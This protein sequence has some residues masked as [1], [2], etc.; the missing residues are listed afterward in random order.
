MTKGKLLDIYVM[1]KLITLY[2]LLL[3]L[4]PIRAQVAE[5]YYSDT[6][7]KE[8]G[9]IYD[10]LKYNNTIIV[11]GR[12]FDK[13]K[14]KPAII[15]IDT[16]GTVLWNTAVND[17]TN[18]SSNIVAGKIMRGNDGYIYAACSDGNSRMEMWKVDP[19]SGS[20]IWKKV[21]NFIYYASLPR[22]M[23][24]FDSTR[25]II[26]YPV[27]YNSVTYH[28]R[29]AFVSKATGD[30]LS[31]YFIGNMPGNMPLYG[32]CLDNQ[33]N[34]YFSK[35]DSIYKVSGSNPNNFIWKKRYASVLILDY[36]QIY[37]DSATSSVFFLGR[38][39]ASWE[40]G[41]IMKIDASIGSLIS[42]YEASTGDVAY[43]DMKVVNDYMYVTW[44]HIYVGGG[45]YPYYLTKY[46]MS[47]ATADWSIDYSFSGGSSSAMSIDLDN[48]GDIYL[49]GYYGSANYG[50]AN[51]GV[52]KIKGTDGSPVYAKT[53]TED[54]TIGNNLSIGMAA[55]V[56]NNTPYFVGELE[57]TH[58]PSMRESLT[59]V[60]LDPS[61]GSTVLRKYIGGYY[62]FP[63][64]TLAIEKYP[65]SQTIVMK[66]TG[67]V[68]ELELYDPAKNLL[69]KKTFVKEYYL[70]GGS[71]AIAPNGDIYM[72]AC[73]KK[74]S[75]SS[76]FYSN[77]TDSVFILQLNSSGGI[78]K[79]Y[80][81]YDGTS[82]ASPVEMYVDYSG[83]LLFYQKNNIIYY[84][85]IGNSLLS[86][87]Y[88]S[89]M[90]YTNVVS[91]TKYC[92]NKNLYKA[93]LFGDFSGT[94]RLAEMDRFTMAITNLA[95]FP[96]QLKKINYALE[97]DTNLV[98]ICAK[99]SLN[100][101]SLGLYNTYIKD[102]VWAKQLSNNSNSQV[103]KCVTD[104]QKNYAY[105]ISQSLANIVV[106]K[107]AISNGQL[108]WAFTYNGAANL[109]DYPV[110]IIYDPYRN[111][112]LVTGYETNSGNKRALIL[113]I[114]S[115]G[116]PLDT[117]IKTGD[118]AGDNYGLCAQVLTDRSQWVGGNLNKNPF[119]SA[120]YIFELADST[121]IP[122][123]R[124]DNSAISV[125]ESVGIVTVKLKIANVN[126]KASSVNIMNTG[127][128][129]VNS[130]YFA[131]IT[132][133]T[134]PASAIDG[135]SIIVTYT[136][137]DDT[138]LESN[139][140]IVAG[141][142]AANNSVVS[143]ASKTITII[144]DD[145]PAIITIDTSALQVFEH[146]GT[147]NV[148]MK[149]ANV[150]G[151]AS[152]VNI[153]NTGTATA[154]SD[155]TAPGPVVTF[156]ASAVNGDS[157]MVTYTIIDD[158]IT[159]STEN[160]IAGFSAGNNAEVVG[161]SKT[162]TIIDND[163]PVTISIDTTA[164]QVYENAGT[165]QV[166]LK[167]SDINGLTSSVNITNT[168][169]A[170]VS[171]DYTAPGP[172]VSF[173]AS[174]MNGDSIIV[175]YTIIDDAIIES[176]ENII[177]GFSKGSNAVVVGGSKIITISDNDSPVIISIDT[178]STQ[179]SENTGTVKVKMK[180]ANVNGLASSISITNTGTATASSDYTA[181]G[182]IITF[183][184]SA[185]N[186]DSIMV[187][188]TI[189][190]D[191]I[192]ESNETIIANFSAG[193]NA[194]VFGTS[195]TI[196]ILDDDAPAI[197]TIDT[198]PIQVLENTGTV[199][200]KMKIANV[201]GKASL[202]NITNTGTATALSDYTS[203]GPVVT[204][205]ASAINGDSIM[206]TYTIKNDTIVESNETI[207]ANFSAG[208][209][210]VVIGAIKTI[211]ILDNDTPAIITVDTSTIQVFESAGSVNVKFKIS[212]VNGQVSSI[213][214]TNTGTAIVPGDY[215][216]PAT[217]V[218]FPASAKNG[219]SI[220]VTYII[221]DDAIKESSE[222][223]I[224]GFTPGING[225][226][227]GNSKTIIIIDDDSP[228]NI[229][230]DTTTLQVSENAGTVMVKLK[231]SNVNGRAAK[232]GLWTTGTAIPG[233]DYT[234][235]T[236]T[237]IFPPTAK[238]GD[239][240]IVY[241]TIIN[242][243]I[244]EPVPETIISTCIPII[245]CILTGGSVQ[246]IRIIDDDPNGID[247]LND[248]ST[249]RIYPNP[250]T[251]KITV[252][253]NNPFP[254]QIILY[255]ATAKKCLQESFKNSVTLNTE[256]LAKGIYFYEIFNESGM[257]KRGKV[258]KN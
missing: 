90:I 177:A 203:P 85:N 27:S 22:F 24:D 68:V 212:K 158:A 185:M 38:K 25:F 256:L 130:D 248:L 229:S 106:R 123:I 89:Q 226:V 14:Y 63:S 209:N 98:L 44:R 211:T 32:L 110:D 109:D 115:T 80:S 31:T 104:P 140:S 67:R 241:Y 2:A 37:F 49:T 197:I 46:K 234:V 13:T 43:S 168:G 10:H 191:A 81:F 250:C 233:I 103:L 6:T 139:E 136:I 56:F 210:A 165:I 253:T 74:E 135:D 206:V 48:S 202:V 190:D 137:N 125:K 69:W 87:E 114:D 9:K 169:T 167:I 187:T 30:T 183:P 208:S 54:S 28:T 4:N 150:N 174:A 147:V 62:Q 251:D 133:V 8:G 108:K 113:V 221:N 213:N 102:T 64:K 217:I 258:I 118:F 1:K 198:T 41:K 257:V 205:P 92:F 7:Q 228:A 186:G 254:S 134:F 96:S 239:S 141:F 163:A 145:A 26:S 39:D 148:K 3:F 154:S 201:N 199:K 244:Y 171:S 192:L 99:N 243:A 5:Y 72:S 59:F 220:M 52:L 151:K 181:P 124:V 73:S 36:Q 159:E 61:T 255:D 132:S 57:T 66:Q 97:T 195:K 40:I 242:D 189:I 84:R 216:P 55:C 188:Y 126:G 164:M 70:Q 76:P 146:S 138:I 127:T 245:N 194:V 207:I 180:I 15:R 23:I 111:Q 232:A 166:K 149:I 16:T 100:Y 60:K 176:T 215:T 219:D 75:N 47:T 19:A 225:V 142:S 50:P 121:I 143:G 156:P 178:S 223:I 224:A 95:I 101:E 35:A 222:T 129:T 160:I 247:L 204:F 20:V 33:K 65:S 17:T 45:Y 175:T 252:I 53:I 88:N 18:Y 93:L 117:I 122:I 120:G 119:G 172:V 86:S 236:S 77:V 107:H 161:A 116:Q 144:D 11:A 42:N 128:A 230:L 105:T 12:S 238:N 82:N 91:S 157:I 235:S 153:T 184:S 83:V 240:I 227:V 34:I 182:P 51:W 58:S 29:F 162:I 218:S 112:L 131:P 237:I 231:I 173:P 94:T 21:Y 249:W 196:T 152:S 246:T 79:Q 179:V 78:I 170:T 71:I 200:V 155:Y 193:S 214:I